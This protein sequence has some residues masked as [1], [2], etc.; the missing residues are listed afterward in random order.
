MSAN[1]SA[2]LLGWDLATEYGR[3][4]ITAKLDFEEVTVQQQS[5]GVGIGKEKS[6]MYD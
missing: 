3:L 5:H 6:S 1:G 4:Y 2:A